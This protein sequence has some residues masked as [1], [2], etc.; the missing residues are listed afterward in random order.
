MKQLTGADE[1]W[2]SLEKPETPMHIN[3]IHIYDPSTAPGGRVSR[4]EILDFIS[5]RLDKVFMR[6]KRVPVPFGLD[7][8][9][10]V[11]DENFDLEHHVRFSTLPKPGDWSQFLKE[12]ARIIEVPLDMSRP[13]WEMHVIEGLNKVEGFPKGCFA[14]VHKKHHGQFDGSAATYLKSQLHT[15]DATSSDLEAFVTE[16]PPAKSVQTPTQMELLYRTGMKT[17]TRAMDR[18]NFVYKTLPNLPR[19]LNAAIKDSVESGTA[20]R[21]RFSA[22]IPSPKRVLEG[23]AFPLKEIQRLRK[24]VPDATI[25]DVVITIFSGAIRKYLLHHNEL[26]KEPVKALVPIAVRKEEEIGA[27]GNKVFSMIIVSH[28]E[29]GD[30]IER[31]KKVHEAAR[32]AKEFTDCIGGRNMCEM[33]EVAP[34]SA[35]D[36]S[37]KMA[38]RMKLANH[39][40][41]L[42]SG[43]S[44]SNVPGSRVPLY[45]AGAQQLR[46]YQ[47][48][49]LMDGM[50]LMLAAGSYMDELVF[51][52][53]SCPEMLPDP[54]FFAQCIQDAFDEL[55]A[56]KLPKAK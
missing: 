1:M 47:W 30:P 52:V 4:Q 46:C 31:L 38:Y 32:N 53:A 6:E 56:V 35:I 5:R 40:Q 45:F 2:F 10:W 25:N 27:G 11:E 12:V 24:H 37:I 8:S 26:P 33:L 42:Y 21:T 7:Y 22:C 23:R 43:V 28:T 49:F 51:T 44:M 19:A 41:P 3:D 20:P 50:G 17:V 34:L 48:G 16:V 39:I 14:V 55:C 18:M 9:Y 54:E 29:V 15:L 13:L 36:S